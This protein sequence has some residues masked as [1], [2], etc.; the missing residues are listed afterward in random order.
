MTKIHKSELIAI[1][2]RDDIRKDND[3]DTCNFAD[4]IMLVVVIMMIIM[5][6]MMFV[7]FCNKFYC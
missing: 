6:M 4:V 7:A 2:N 5:V 3:D 1:I